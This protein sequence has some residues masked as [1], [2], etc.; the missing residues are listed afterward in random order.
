MFVGLA[1]LGFPVAIVSTSGCKKAE[2]SPQSRELFTNTCARC[3]GADGT[4]GLPLWE[5]GPSPQNFHDHAFQ[6]SRTDEQIM[7]VIRNGKG[8]GM[9]A[10]GALLSDEQIMQLAMQ[11]RSFDKAN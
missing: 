2:A 6:A 3:H 8:T 11:V 1:L 10:F 7:T 4:G 9:P 5:A